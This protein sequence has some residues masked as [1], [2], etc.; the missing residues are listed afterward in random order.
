MCLTL[1]TPNTKIEL[2]DTT[3][4]QPISLMPC[5]RTHF[6]DAMLP[7]YMSYISTLASVSSPTSYIIFPTSNISPYYLLMHLTYVS[8]SSVPN[9]CSPLRFSRNSLLF[10]LSICMTLLYSTYSS[11]DSYLFPLILDVL[12]YFPS[13]FNIVYYM[14]LLSNSQLFLL[15][16][17]SFSGVSSLILDTPSYF[18]FVF[19]F[20]FWVNPVSYISHSRCLY[21]ISISFPRI[22]TMCNAKCVSSSLYLYTLFHLHLCVNS[23]GHPTLILCFHLVIVLMLTFHSKHSLVFISSK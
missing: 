3:A 22:P 12:V 6:H 1:C 7:P 20:V 19:N 11:Y 8:L 10:P 4:C 23:H 13:I 9:L 2:P 21:L 14:Y 18:P 5:T 16:I 15:L 17:P